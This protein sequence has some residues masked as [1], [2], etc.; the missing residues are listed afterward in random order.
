[1]VLRH[2]KSAARIILLSN[3]DN[4]KLFSISFRTPPVDSSGL[5]HILEHSVLCGSRAFPV[6]EPFVELAKGSLNS[7]LNAM[8]FPDKTMYPIASVN[9]K[10]F[11]NLM[12]VYMDAVL[13][14]RIY[15]SPEI[16]KQEGWHY[17]LEN[18]DSPLSYN[19]V[20]YNEMKGAYSSAESLL[21]KN[22][23][24]K[25]YP[26]TPYA[27]DSGGDPDEITS[28]RYEDFRDFHTRYYHPSNSYIVL[29]GKFNVVEKLSW[30]DS[31]Y[32]ADFEAQALDSAIPLQTPF[33]SIKQSE[34]DYPLAASESETSKAML[35]MSWVIG[36]IPD[37]KLYYACMVLNYLLLWSQAAPL[38][39]A[40]IDA[41]IC[42]DVTGGYSSEMRQPFFS[43]IAK[44]ARRE[45]RER[46]AEIVRSTLA[47]LANG[48]IDKNMLE[49]ALTSIE[50]QIR[51]ANSGG[52]P[53]GLLIAM[54]IMST[55]LYDADPFLLLEYEN[56]FAELREG[57]NSGYFEN[58]IRRYFVENTH[59]AIVCANPVCGLNAVKEKDLEEKLARYRDSL[60][61]EQIATIVKETSYLKEFQE[62]PDTAENLETIPLLEISD[63]DK[64]TEILPL[65]MRDNGSLRILFSELNTNSILYSGFYFDCA[66]L[67]PDLVPYAG[68]LSRLLGK[69]DTVNYT[70]QEL[71]QQIDIHTGG[72][73]ASVQVYGYREE[74]EVCVP[75]MEIKAKALY[76]KTD[77]MVE[78][79]GEILLKSR[80][81]DTK[82]IFELL[83][84]TRSRMKMRMG[85]GLD[86]V[87][88]VRLMSYFS[89]A[90]RFRDGANGI[91]FYRFLDELV[92]DF[93]SRK[94][95]LVKK[96]E[97]LRESLFCAE[98]LVCACTC[99]AA[100]ADGFIQNLKDFTGGLG[101]IKDQPDHECFELKTGN[102]G[103]LDSG[104]VHYV[105]RGGNFVNAGF[106]YRGA[107]KVLETIIR[108]DY[109]WKNVRVMGGAY[110][111]ACAFYRNGNAFFSSYRD[112]KLSETLG[113][114]EAL[115]GY[116]EKFEASEREMKK[117]IIGTVSKLDRPLIAPLKG[118]TAVM[119]WF[120]RVSA[121][122]LQ[123][124]RDEI[125]SVNQR[126]IRELAPLVRAVLSQNIICVIGNE[127]TIMREKSLFDTTTPLFR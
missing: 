70:Y 9:D 37:V 22:I 50:F 98:N 106:Q 112:P 71:D 78:L 94:S 2:R 82:R 119:N 31:A 105:V 92:N 43:V 117:Y 17:E 47:Q 116:L 5:P 69:L 88:A 100:A 86:S 1:M 68:I 73:N 83:K 124:E 101:R 58:I 53:K 121:E 87:A 40:L 52:Y 79:V 51:E 111:A 65:E 18:S 10:D 32:L 46:F 45:D 56:I 120:N 12:H 96:L 36:E 127:N 14:P 8:T 23:Q 77:K 85:Q 61:A 118:D 62:T 67:P 76:A 102:E 6:K 74:T 63:I 26:D 20:V 95:D 4:N 84:Q 44:E 104:E 89:M 16:F 91:A 21:F 38:K 93:E 19:G 15:Q 13:Y 3:N 115:P 114:Y 60:S 29:Y 27:R 99:D 110:G 54:D 35:S 66:K 107:L 80:F 30:L 25:L 39:R 113:V 90:Q 103:F 97:Y 122:R 34:F 59:A 126:M 11:Q 123:A 55:W 64:K 75:K 108:L 42:N 72:V 81:D 49:A 109:L 125:L 48:G 24:E 7:F 28:L 57:M 41:N 33:D